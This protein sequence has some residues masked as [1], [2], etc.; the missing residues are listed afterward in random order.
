MVATLFLASTGLLHMQGPSEPSF[1]TAVYERHSKSIIAVQ[2]GNRQGTGFV[3]NGGLLFTCW[4]VVKGSLNIQVKSVDE[5]FTLSRVIGMN[6]EADI[7]VFE[8][9]EAKSL[10]KP[11]TK[12]DVLDTIIEERRSK[13][14]GTLPVL[15]DYASCKIGED[16]V[17]IGSPLG[18]NQTLTKGVI[19]SKRQVGGY[20]ALQVTAGATHGSS[21]SPVFNK[22]GAVIG[23]VT[24]GVS[25]AQFINFAVSSADLK[26]CQGLELSDI[27]D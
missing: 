2:A 1:A 3:I 10:V 5:T 26:N 8:F 4:H 18:L 11:G 16:V 24:S 22:K 13:Q 19:S 12:L 20:R 27:R 25:E 7:V 9:P 6:K 15:G 23:M 14:W 17:I 21:G